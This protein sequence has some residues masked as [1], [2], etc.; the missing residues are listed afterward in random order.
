MDKLLNTITQ[1]LL[2]KSFFERCIF[3]CLFCVCLYSSVNYFKNEEQIITQKYQ[4]DFSSIQQSILALFQAHTIQS[5]CSKPIC[6][7]Q[8]IIFVN[9]KNYEN[10]SIAYR[11]HTFPATMSTTKYYMSLTC[12][13]MACY[14]FIRDFENLPPIFIT[15]IQSF[16]TE[17]LAIHNSDTTNSHFNMMQQNNNATPF[18]NQHTHANKANQV[19]QESSQQDMPMSWKQNIKII[20]EIQRIGI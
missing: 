3:F 2:Q 16:N 18:W 5:K 11:P 6:T 14:E 12:N 8:E 20:F 10:Q 15:E 13:S 7:S 1:Y 4:T 9:R 19:R 17:I